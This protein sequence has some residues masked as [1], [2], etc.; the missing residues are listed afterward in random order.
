MQRFKEV[1]KIESNTPGKQRRPGVAMLL[2]IG[3]KNNFMDTK[4]SCFCLFVCFVFC[5]FRA[6]V[7]AYGCSQ[8]RGLIGATAAG[9][10]HSS[11]QCQIL[12]PLSKA[13]IEPA[14]S[15]LLVGFISTVPRRE[16]PRK[17]FLSGK[18]L[19]S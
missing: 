2:S 3:K 19:N 8:A 14:T 5:L 7:A 6:A 9:L 4:K 15:W 17:A 12:N 10:H 1:E 11:Q 18:E 13:R 16:F